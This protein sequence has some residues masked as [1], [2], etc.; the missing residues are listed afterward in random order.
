MRHSDVRTGV[1]SICRY[2]IRNGTATADFDR[3]LL[4]SD[5]HLL[6]HR[7]VQRLA[8]KSDTNCVLCTTALE[9]QQ[10][11]TSASQTS[12]LKSVKLK[13]KSRAV[14]TQAG[15]ALTPCARLKKLSRGNDDGE[16]YNSTSTNIGPSHYSIDG[17]YGDSCNDN[18]VDP[19]LQEVVD[20][21]DES[22]EPLTGRSTYVQTDGKSRSICSLVQREAQ[23]NSQ[24]MSECS[25]RPIQCP[26]LDCA[27][28]VAFSA[29]TNHFIFDHPEVP[30]LSVD[31]GE[32]ITL[33][34]NFEGLD[35]D[36]S[37]CLALLL[38]SGKLSGLAAK[39]F[40]GSHVSAEY[41]SRL[42]LPIL[43]ARLHCNAS[44]ESHIHEAYGERSRDDEGDVVIAWVAGLDIGNTTTGALRCSIQAIDSIDGEAFRSLTYTGPINSLRTAQKPREVFLV[45]DCVVLHDGFINHIMSGCG[46]LNVNVTIH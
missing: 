5:G 18:W 46:N 31:S 6:C 20:L 26:R 19:E 8:I 25:R 40:N 30:I 14:K 11:I 42:P 9:S 1:C 24:M 2:S 33:V 28:N 10:S 34:V 15:S 38:V 22:M 23:I 13:K 41:K 45:G 7:C 39:S 3:A 21:E 35:Y 32:T 27:V 4:C 43:A 16:F 37:R 44:R 17:G 36:S 12:S 29:L